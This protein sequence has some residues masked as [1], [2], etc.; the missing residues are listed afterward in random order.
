MRFFVSSNLS[1]KKESNQYGYTYC[2]TYAQKCVTS[3]SILS[4]LTMKQIKKVLVAAGILILVAFLVIIFNQVMQVYLYASAVNQTFGIV[5]ATV[6][7]MVFLALL[8]APIL[9]FLR[10]PKALIPPDSEEEMTDYLPKLTGRLAKNKLLTGHTFD[11]SQKEDVQRA[12]AMLDVR[13]NEIIQKTARNVFLATSISQNGKLD[14]LMVLSTHTKMLWDIAHIYYQRPAPRDLLALYSNVA[15]TTLLAS[16]LED[17]DISEQIEPVL[18]TVLQNSAMKSIPFIGP[19]SS[20]A[21]DSLM[22]GSINAFLTL[23]VGI[24]AKRYC[25]TLEP[26]N[27]KKVRKAAL[28]EASGMLRTLVMQTSG[29]VVSSI[30]KATKNAGIN[31]VKSGVAMAGRATNTVKK[32]FFGW[33]RRA[34]PT[35][36]QAE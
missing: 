1:L 29:Q 17:L 8:L 28:I 23:R 26:F 21:L 5:V 11:W 19:M 6:L 4:I 22:E 13:T 10:L 14:A 36:S 20:V 25:G 32:G 24:I 2:C 33:F 35:P 3:V 15:A 34:E 7:G 9:L 12:L 31:T 18:G 30:M 27:A 16:Q